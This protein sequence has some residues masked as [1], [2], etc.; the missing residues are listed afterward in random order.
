MKQP[1]KLIG[2]GS[3][4]WLVPFIVAIFFYTADGELA[5]D[6]FLFKSLM[7]VVAGIFNTT[8][9]V[10]MFRTVTDEYIRT[11][12][13]IGLTWLAINIGLD[14]I[15]LVGMLDTNLATYFREIGLGYLIIPIISIAMGK[16]IAQSQTAVR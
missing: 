15:V 6:K 7:L 3:L 11:G 5:I 13:I 2:F 4:T 12:I 10:L 1:I 8:L 14:L 16:A 9:L